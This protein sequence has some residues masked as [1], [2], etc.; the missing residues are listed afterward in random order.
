MPS[1]EVSSHNG[2]FALRLTSSIKHKT[3]GCFSL[4]TGSYIDCNYVNIVENSLG[5]LIMEIISSSLLAAPFTFHSAI[6]I[7]V[8]FSMLYRGTSPAVWRS[9]PDTTLLQL[10]RVYSSVNNTATTSRRLSCDKWTSETAA[11][12]CPKIN[13]LVE[14]KTRPLLFDD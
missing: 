4:C 3:S 2:Y 9:G 13:L 10:G 7:G 6:F 11:A 5:P 14:V 12:S 8:W 1:I